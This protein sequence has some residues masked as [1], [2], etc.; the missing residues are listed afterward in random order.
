[1]KVKKILAG[2]IIITL[3]VGLAIS[4]SAGSTNSKKPIMV[5]ECMEIRESGS[6]LLKN[7]LYFEGTECI[8]IW[9]DDVT[10]NCLGHK[11]VS[12]GDL[13]RRVNIYADF[14]DNLTI[15]NCVVKG[16]T[17]GIFAQFVSNGMIKNNSAMDS[18]DTGIFITSFGKTELKNNFASGNGTG[19]FLGG[20]DGTVKNSVSWN[21]GIGLKV[22]GMN[23]D[24]ERNFVCKNELDL[25]CPVSHYS[26]SGKNNFIGNGE[27]DCGEMT[28]RSCPK[29]SWL[30]RKLFR[31]F[32][33]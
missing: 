2:L 11:I 14:V 31:R 30:W 23:L 8:E 12:T 33:R 5:S 29:R 3:V 4:A 26:I 32:S 6:Y 1:M 21:N 20:H 19:I 7:D 15:K 16:G 10:F 24:A 28:A 25:E 27:I 18:E 17:D 13:A 22:W 9:V